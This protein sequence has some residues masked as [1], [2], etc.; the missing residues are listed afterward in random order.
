MIVDL[1]DAAKLPLGD[2]DV[3]I[4]GAGPAGISTALELARQRPDWHI[5]LLEGGGK[6][7]P[8]A[9]NLD[10]YA[11][12]SVGDRPY[13]LAGSRLRYL[14]G[15][16]N[17]WGGWCRPLDEEDFEARAWMPHSGWPLRR[18]ELL[19]W[20]EKATTW[21]ELGSNEFSEAALTPGLG[22]ALLHVDD[23]SVLCNKFFRFS[24]PTRFGKR[25][26][27]DLEKA[28][29]LHLLLH[30]NAV[31]MDMAGERVTGVRIAFGKDGTATLA[32]RQVV[33]ALGGI[34]TTRFLLLQ[35]AQAPAGSGLASP[36]LGRC[37]ADHFGMTP[38]V[39][40]LPEQLRYD[41]NPHPTGA[42]MPVLSLS[43]AAQQALQVPDFCVM[44]LPEAQASD[45]SPAYAGNAALGLRHGRYWRYR[46]QMIIEPRPNPD[47]RITLTDERDRHGVPRLRLDWRVADADRRSVIECLDDLAAELGEFGLGRLRMLDE[48]DY[49]GG[50]PSVGFHHLGSARMASDAEGGVVDADCR[51]HGIENL[52][53]ASSAV[54]PSFGFSNP[55]LTIVALATRLAARLA[56]AGARGAAEKS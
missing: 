19:P 55:T 37:F 51:V 6:H 2:C 48:K 56:K 11:G 20:Y 21:C 40:L 10:A 36:M 14:G 54:F 26:L 7:M 15:T 18:D 44:P 41:R 23:S 29:N 5:V 35:A 17:H 42:V 1:A 28:P 49:L 38:A 16:S 22:D 33:V 45:L 46:L 24:P 12:A 31:G 50:T 32:A 8:S 9:A 13:P 25:Y 3:C 27:A 53:V 47:S 39:A 34:E 52:H 4:L 30:A 43:R